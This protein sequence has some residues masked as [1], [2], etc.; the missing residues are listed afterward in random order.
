MKKVLFITS[1]FHPHVGG[2]ETM[3]K[4]LSSFYRMKGLEVVCLTKK[5]PETLFSYE[6]YNETDIYRVISARTEQE[7]RDLVTWAKVNESK[8]KSDIIHVVGVRRPLPLLGLLL[9]RRWKVPLICTIAGGDIPD[10]EDPQPTKVWEE[11]IEFIP[12]VLKQS[13]NV[14]CVSK[15]LANNLRTLVPELKNDIE[16]LYAGLDISTIKDTAREKIKGQYIFSLRRLDSSKGI[17]LLIKAFSLI[18]DKFP[19]LYLVIAGE[20]PEEQRLRQLAKDCCENDRVLFIGTVELKRGI[21]LLKGAAV[22]VVPSLSEGGG[23]VNI[24]AQ[25]AGCP[26]IASRVGGIPEYVKEN[27]SGLLFESGN[28]AELASKISE[29]LSNNAL[30][31]KIIQGGYIHSQLFDWDVLAPQ[32]VS[33]YK[34]TIDTYQADKQFRPWSHLTKMLQAEFK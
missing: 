32:Y 16:V 18:K 34:A 10:K 28:F 19:Q 23:L 8:I 7:F 26:V 9:A 15:A 12:E 11:G 25:A 3:V 4:E 13:D 17:D 27:E 33:L 5:W 2:I 21:A 30:R 24:E 14:N 29:V 1:L 20:G 6:R 31:L 22:T